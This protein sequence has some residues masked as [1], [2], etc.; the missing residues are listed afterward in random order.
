M[1]QVNFYIVLSHIAS[2]VA[3]FVSVAGAIW[4]FLAYSDQSFASG[5]VI[6][7]AAAAPG[8]FLLIISEGFFILS[9]ILKEKK[10]QTKILESIKDGLKIDE[11]ISHN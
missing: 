3:L 1:K 5:V 7:V 6:A 10:A 2:G 9:E 4:G 8:V 11:K